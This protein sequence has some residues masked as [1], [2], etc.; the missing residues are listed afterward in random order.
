MEL[1]PPAM[2]VGEI[3]MAVSTGGCTVRVA[4]ALVAPTVAVTVA[5]LAAAT[6]KVA[7][8]TVAAYWPG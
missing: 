3:C 5:G 7:T 8:S 1:P 6:G 2:L 4:E